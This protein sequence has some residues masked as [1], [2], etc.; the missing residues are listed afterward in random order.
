MCAETALG[1]GKYA[2]VE[3]HQD[4]PGPGLAGK[5]RTKTRRALCYIVMPFLRIAT[6]RQE[7]NI[8]VYQR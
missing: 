4:S 5:D 7:K 1:T 3:D 2:K 6:I 8:S